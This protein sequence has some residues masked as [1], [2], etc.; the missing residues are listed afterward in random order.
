MVICFHFIQDDEDDDKPMN[1]KQTLLQRYQLTDDFNVLDH[2]LKDNNL[3]INKDFLNKTDD[4]IYIYNGYN[5]IF[6]YTNNFICDVITSLE[7]LSYKKYIFE[8]YNKIYNKINNL[9]NYEVFKTNSEFLKYMNFNYGNIFEIMQYSGIS[10]ILLIHPLIDYINLIKDNDML[11]EYIYAEVNLY[12]YNQN[13]INKIIENKNDEKQIEKYRKLIIDEPK[14]MI[15]FY[16]EFEL[17]ENIS[18]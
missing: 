15:E 7:S 3:S 9:I 14:L 11:H 13:I 12:K 5:K 4:I 16:G 8:K 6:V 10:S 17:F 1:F 2:F 18:D